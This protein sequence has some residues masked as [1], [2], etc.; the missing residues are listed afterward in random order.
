MPSNEAFLRG[1]FEFGLGCWQ[2]CLD[3]RYVF[4]YRDKKIPFEA[5]WLC[6]GNCIN[7]RRLM[8]QMPNA[9]IFLFRKD[10]I[11]GFE[12]FGTKDQEEG[13]LVFGSETY[14]AMRILFSI[15]QQTIAIRP[16]GAFSFQ[17]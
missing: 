5:I 10:F 6:G 13:I 12:W 17:P 1:H 14:S 9:K 16:P 15:N 3:R 7:G 11:D 4:S 2:T 8:H